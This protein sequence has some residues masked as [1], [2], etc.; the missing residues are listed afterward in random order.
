MRRPDAQEGPTPSR[1]NGGR[2]HPAA[3]FFPLLSA[4][5]KPPGGK[6]GAHA[7]NGGNP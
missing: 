6:A 2:V 4:K 7:Q 3:P 5:K 1:R